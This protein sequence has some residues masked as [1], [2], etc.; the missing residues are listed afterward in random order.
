MHTKGC[1][2][3]VPSFFLFHKFTIVF[4]WCASSNALGLNALAV[5]VQCKLS[6]FT[7]LMDKACY[8]VDILW[9]FFWCEKPHV[10]TTSFT[11]TWFS[12]WNKSIVSTVWCGLPDGIRKKYTKFF[13]F[14]QYNVSRLDAYRLVFLRYT[15][16]LVSVSP[17]PVR[18]GRNHLVSVTA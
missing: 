17:Y 2:Y 15:G 4:R 3:L 6:R 10:Q 7:A 8:F 12:A 14:N 13:I 9:P 1:T 5:A 18:V 11:G 16:Y